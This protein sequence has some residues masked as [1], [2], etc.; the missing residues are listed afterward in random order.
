[1]DK[2]EILRTIYDA[3]LRIITTVATIALTALGAGFVGITIF[4]GITLNSERTRLENLEK[5]VQLKGAEQVS[6]VKGLEGQ[7]TNRLEEY[8]RSIKT[9][10]QGVQAKSDEQVRRVD[11]VILKTQKVPRVVALVRSGIT[12]PGNTLKARIMRQGG[13][14]SM[15][16]AIILKNEGTATSDPLFLKWY[17]REPLRTRNVVA[18]SDEPGYDY[19]LIGDSQNPSA[20]PPDLPKVL[21]AQATMTYRVVAPM[22]R[23]DRNTK[24]FPMAL[25]I[26]YGAETPYRAEFSAEIQD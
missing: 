23:L 18:S 7:I 25:K 10:E 16:F 9:L 26:Y 21:P 14:D 1:M 4:S 20:F 13:Q 11:M 3:K 15:V 22:E 17:F 12:L 2:E 6:T 5:Q 24:T 19:E 8:R